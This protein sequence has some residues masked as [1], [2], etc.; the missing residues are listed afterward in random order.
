M[1]VNTEGHDIYSEWGKETNVNRIVMRK[2][3]GKSAHGRPK[4]RWK[5]VES[6]GKK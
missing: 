2:F 1:Y 4:W 6:Y 3:F 5:A